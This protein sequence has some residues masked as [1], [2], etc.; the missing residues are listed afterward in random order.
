MSAYSA[1]VLEHFRRPRR[2]G[3][4]ESPSVSAEGTNP[5]CGDRVRVQL[6]VADGRVTAARFTAEACAV[7]VAAASLLLERVEGAMLDDI[8]G[9][10]AEDVIA[11]LDVTLPPARRRCAT[12]ALEAVHDAVATAREAGA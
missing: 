10:G 7:S 4:L 9:I 6:A 8:A 1:T 12:L 11:L 3:A 5:L 2:S